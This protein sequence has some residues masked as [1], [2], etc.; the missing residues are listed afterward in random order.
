MNLFSIRRVFY[1]RRMTIDLLNLNII[2]VIP[3]LCVLNGRINVSKNIR[4]LRHHNL[5][6]SIT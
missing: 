4:R 5:M 1:N 2:R 3:R 6:F